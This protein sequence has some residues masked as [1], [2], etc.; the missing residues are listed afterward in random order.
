MNETLTSDNLITHDDFLAISRRCHYNQFISQFYERFADDNRVPIALHGDGEIVYGKDSNFVRRASRVKSCCNNW[1]FDF[2]PKLKYKNLVRVERCDDRFC[3]N[4]QALKADQRF[5]QHAPRFDEFIET[6]DMYHVVLTVPNVEAYRLRDTVTMM[7]DRFAYLIRFFQGSKKIKGVDFARYGYLGAVRSLEITVSKRDGTFHPHLHC[8][9][10]LKKNLDLP[11]VFWNKFSNDRTGRTPCRL[12][13][14]LDILIQRIWCL[15]ICKKKVTAE[16]IANIEEVT[17]YSDGFSC[18]VDLS[19][20]KYHEVFKYAIKG[21]FKNETLFTYENFL[22]L[23]NALYDRRCYQSYG[24]L[25]GIDFNEVD[26]TLGLG[27]KDEA[28]DL[29]ITKLKWCEIPMRMEQ[30]LGEILNE[31]SKGEMKF[32]S[33]ATFVRHFKSLSEEDKA[34]FLDKLRSELDREDGEDE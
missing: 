9:F 25:S 20:G 10:V 24:C 4:C 32:I 22:T 18:R 19:N 33:K 11:Q 28:F 31:S 27:G 34:M 21:S 12:M 14:E 6:N 3:L 1:T 7:L 23:Y 13:S 8:I 15:L 26:E 29:F 30:L 5:V 16:N 2:Y 17:G